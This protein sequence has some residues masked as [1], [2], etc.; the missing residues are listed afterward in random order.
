MRN[1]SPYNLLSPELTLKHG[2]QC[3]GIDKQFDFVV[4]YKNGHIGVDVSD[5]G[6]LVFTEM[7][8]YDVK[9][10]IRFKALW[11]TM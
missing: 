8:L 3:I 6:V 2:I 11:M 10:L 1:E 7:A 4:W 5:F 9:K